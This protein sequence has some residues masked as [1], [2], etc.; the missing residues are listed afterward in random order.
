[1]E[2]GE[3][4]VEQAKPE[5]LQQLAEKLEEQADILTAEIEQTAS[6]P[7]RKAIRSRRSLL[8]KPAKLIREDFLPRLEKY[9]H[10]HE[11]FG[12]R[13]SF[14]TIDPDATFMR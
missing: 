12:D 14:S 8:R 1:M 6:A 5:E 2:L 11:L 3:F 4:P 7:E 9:A 10:H 13:N